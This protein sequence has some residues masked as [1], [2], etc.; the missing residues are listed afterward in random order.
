MRQI[1]FQFKR[2]DRHE[3]IKLFLDDETLHDDFFV[4]DLNKIRFTFDK[5]RSK[6]DVFDS[7]AIYHHFL[8]R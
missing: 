4:F 1:D 6:F 7:I 8:V 3:N 2:V 5:F